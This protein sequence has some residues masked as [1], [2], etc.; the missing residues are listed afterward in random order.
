V[1]I[2]P[3]LFVSGTQAIVAA[4]VTSGLGYLFGTVVG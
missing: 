1:P 2:L 4:A 3:F